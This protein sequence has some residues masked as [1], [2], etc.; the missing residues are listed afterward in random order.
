[1]TLKKYTKYINA[2]SKSGKV[3]NGKIYIEDIPYILESEHER[4][5]DELQK[6]RDK[7]N[8][9]YIDY[10]CEIDN[11]Q[12]ERSNL[13][14]KVSELKAENEKLKME[15]DYCSMISTDLLNESKWISVEDESPKFIEGKTY[16][17]NVFAICKELEGIQ[18]F[19][20]CRQYDD[21]GDVFNGW[22]NCY[23]KI[24]G[25]SE[26]DDNYTIT[27]WKRISKTL[28]NL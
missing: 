15:R 3:Y 8:E 28:P 19:A 21:N 9:L 7:F 10:G 4:I 23:G 13:E 5:V 24:D 18:V 12:L 27:H 11:L 2:I 20:F 6:E 1:M 17:E 22:A 14:S 16:S 25:D 26:W